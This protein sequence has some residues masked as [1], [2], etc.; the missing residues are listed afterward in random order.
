[1][2]RNISEYPNCT[3][4]VSAL[5]CLDK[6]RG[7]VEMTAQTTTTCIDDLHGYE[8]FSEVMHS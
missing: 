4:Y 1:M 5:I 8:A 2:V 7:S 3:N 6:V